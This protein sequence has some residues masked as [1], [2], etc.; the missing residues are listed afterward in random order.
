MGEIRA[1]NSDEA[2]TPSRSS[3]ISRIKSGFAWWRAAVLK[4]YMRARQRHAPASPAPEAYPQGQAPAP[5]AKIWPV[6]GLYPHSTGTGRHGQSR[7]AS[8]CI[9]GR[10]ARSC[11]RVGTFANKRAGEQ[12][13]EELKVARA[14]NKETVT[15]TE[16]HQGPCIP[17]PEDSIGLPPWPK[18]AECRG[19][20][21]LKRTANGWES[22]I[23]LRTAKAVP[24]RAGIK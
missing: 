3:K 22:I 11:R 19:G 4:K 17:A 6:L 2:A 8:N 24:C 15:V 13:L 12:A 18:D 10:H 9:C 7:M 23:D 14:A 20:V 1:L 21:L 16:V 5:R